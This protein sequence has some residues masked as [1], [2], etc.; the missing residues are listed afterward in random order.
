MTWKSKIIGLAMSLAVLAALALSSGA[1]SWL[2]LFDITSFD[3]WL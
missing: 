1:D 2:S 3:S